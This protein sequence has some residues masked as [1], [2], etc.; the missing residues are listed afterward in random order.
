MLTD[1]EHLL[2]TVAFGADRGKKCVQVLIKTNVYRW[3]ASTV[4][5]LLKVQRGVN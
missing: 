3:V 5:G 4:M 1:A 2:P